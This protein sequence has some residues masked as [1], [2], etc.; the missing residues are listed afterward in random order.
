[1][2]FFYICALFSAPVIAYLV[3]MLLKVDVR[4]LIIVL[5][6]FIVAN[7]I[8]TL[9]SFGVFFLNKRVRDHYRLLIYLLPTILCVLFWT[10]GVMYDAHR[11]GKM[12]WRMSAIVVAPHV[13]NLGLGMFF[14]SLLKKDA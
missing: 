5:P 14:I 11:L 10:Y 9:I 1:M 4:A 12:D 8:I 2:V 13:I 3:S 7:L 6:S